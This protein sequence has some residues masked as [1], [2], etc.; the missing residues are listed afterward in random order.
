MRFLLLVAA[1]AFSFAAGD[2]PIRTYVAGLD[3]TSVTL[4]WG[5]ADGA[6]RNTIGKGAEGSGEAIVKIDGRTIPS[7]ASWTRIDGL[8]PD[9]EYPYSVTLNRVVVASAA[10]RT[11][12]AKSS[13]LTFFVIGD[14]GN[15]SK[16]QHA[17]AARMEEERLR[18]EKSDR[19]VRFVLTTGD[20]IYGKLSASGA[21][22]RDWE[23]KYFR[24]YARTLLAIPFKAVLGNHDGNESEKTADLAACLDNFFMPDRWYRFEYASFVEFIALD[25]TRNQPTGRTAPV[26]LAGG[27]QSKWLAA[28]L[29]KPPLPWRL[30]AMHHPLFTAGPNHRPFAA[31]VPHWFLAMRSAGVQAVF[32][33]HEHN[34]QFSERNAETGNIQ[35]VV[36]GAGGELRNNS[37]RKKMTANHIASWSNQY[38]FLV[39]HI[40]GAQMAIEPIGIAPINLVDSTGK[41]ATI[42]VTVPTN[43]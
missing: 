16:D 3:S 22:D 7:S 36:S 15:G 24:P 25:S 43:R 13:E 38:H 19:P 10:I 40:T 9:T 29:A 2:F 23:D 32:A 12:P 42:P 5:T 34:L 18:L 41:A 31:S 37:V 33:G 26:F 1:S 39:V 17:L 8:K 11:W 28:T 6:G 27:D 4:A 14:F 21:Q 30:V 35:F 20:N